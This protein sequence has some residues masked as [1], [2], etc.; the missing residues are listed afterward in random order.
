MDGMRFNAHVRGH[1][2]V[3]DAP[4]RV[5]GTDEGPVPK[6]LVLNALAGCTG[7]YVTGLLRK[8]GRSL[9]TCTIRV[10]GELSK[11]SPMAY[12]AAHTACE[13][14]GNPED[15]QVLIGALQ[16]SQNEL[17]GVA[18]MPRYSMPVTW[19][20]RFNGALVVRGEGPSPV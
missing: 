10:R 9:R 20:L 19:E 6:P 5:C 2:A 16:R 13:A 1:T 8:K 11:R 18:A 15:E 7:M 12:V 3:M 17:C 4:E 14:A